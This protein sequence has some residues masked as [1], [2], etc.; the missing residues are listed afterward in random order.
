MGVDLNNWVEVIN[1]HPL[2][3]KFYGLDCFHESVG[4]AAASD[5]RFMENWMADVAENQAEELGVNVEMIKKEGGEIGEWD[6]EANYVQWL[7]DKNHETDDKDDEDYQDDQSILICY[8]DKWERLYFVSERQSYDDCRW[9][10]EYLRSEVAQEYLLEKHPPVEVWDHAYEEGVALD[11]VLFL[12]PGC[13]RNPASEENE[14]LWGNWFNC[15]L[16]GGGTFVNDDAYLCLVDWCEDVEAEIF[17]FAPVKRESVLAEF[18]RLKQDYA[19][20]T[21]ACVDS[22]LDVMNFTEWRKAQKEN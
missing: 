18:S 6:E 12:C 5:E 11:K 9:E 21:E 19:I 20:Y 7:R 22:D 1:R 13:G 15:G 16:C 10:W 4:D 3:Y 14:D 8:D 2:K 17:P